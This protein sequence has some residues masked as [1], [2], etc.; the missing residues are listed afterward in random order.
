MYNECFNLRRKFIH[1]YISQNTHTHS[2]SSQSSSSF[3]VKKKHLSLGS[4]S[5]VSK[6][7]NSEK[8]TNSTSSCKDD[9]YVSNKFA[10]KLPG[11]NQVWVPR[12]I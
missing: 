6:T 8:E 3:K 9:D 1:G 11:P 7:H 12:K 10:T 2:D 5:L 4:K